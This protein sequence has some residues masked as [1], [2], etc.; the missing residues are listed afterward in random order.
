[1]KSPPF[2]SCVERWHGTP[3]RGNKLRPQNLVF[4]TLGDSLKMKWPPLFPILIVNVHISHSDKTRNPFVASKGMDRFSNGTFV[5]N[6]K[7]DKKVF[8]AKVVSLNGTDCSETENWCNFPFSGPIFQLWRWISQ[9][10]GQISSNSWWAP[11]F[12]WH[13]VSQNVQI[14]AVTQWEVLKSMVLWKVFFVSF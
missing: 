7:T 4:P 8:L 2:F 1:M 13:E 12:T 10:F 14:I 3:L 6:S 11:G 9:P 5:M